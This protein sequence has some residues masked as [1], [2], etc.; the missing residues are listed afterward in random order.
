MDKNYDEEKHIYDGVVTP[1]DDGEGQ[2]VSDRVSFF[3]KINHFLNRLGGEE[4]GIERVLPSEKTDQ[5]PFIP[6]LFN[7]CL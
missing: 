6:N 5:V 1:P 3:R 2:A 7:L 4:R